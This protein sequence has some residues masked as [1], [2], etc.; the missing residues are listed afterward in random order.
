MESVV[1]NPA[2]SHDRYGNMTRQQRVAQTQ[3]TGPR[4]FA[5]MEAQQR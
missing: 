5:R 1:Y 4:L 3:E 2:F